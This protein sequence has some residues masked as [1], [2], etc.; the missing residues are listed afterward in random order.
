MTSYTPYVTIRVHRLIFNGQIN[1]LAEVLPP[2]FANCFLVWPTLINL[3]DNRQISA[4]NELQRKF[5]RK[6]SLLPVIR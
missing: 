6:N 4:K 3:F 5:K 2:L 1:E